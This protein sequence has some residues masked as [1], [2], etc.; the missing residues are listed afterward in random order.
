[1]RLALPADERSHDSE[2]AD[3][4]QRAGREERRTHDQVVGRLGEAARL[5][6]HAFEVRDDSDDPVERVER[7]EERQPPLRCLLG[8]D[9]RDPGRRERRRQDDR[10]PHPLVAEG[11]LVVLEVDLE[12][13][14]R[15]AERRRRGEQL[16]HA[17]VAD[18]LDRSCDQA[19]HRSTS[20][21]L[22]SS[23][24]PGRE[25]SGRSTPPSGSGTPSKSMCS[26]RTWSWKYS[27]CRRRSTAQNACAEIAGAQCAETS[28]SCALA[29][30]EADSTPVMPPHR[31]T[32]ACRT[33]TQA[34]TFRK[35]AGTYAYS[36][37]A[38]SMPAGPRSRTR[39]SPS[40]SADETGSSNHDTFHSSAYRSAQPSA[41][42]AV[43][44]PFAS[45]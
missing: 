33:S 18:V 39:R 5:L 35:S 22:S 44:A 26:I 37:A 30:P 6:P 28:T 24:F 41:S 9:A 31:V 43:K 40:K 32:S 42:F 12:R 16:L 11:A 15:R 45:T 38:T 14:R 8:E 17:A 4:R 23:P 29:R 25:R 10:R 19:D 1:M 2:R 27:R 36:P 13:E 7:A 3:H 20:C 34:T 21:R